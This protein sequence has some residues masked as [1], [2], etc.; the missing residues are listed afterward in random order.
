[1]A[2][3]SLVLNNLSF[4]CKLEQYAAVRAG[5][6]LEPHKQRCSGRPVNAQFQGDPQCSPGDSDKSCHRASAVSV[7]YSRWHV[8]LHQ[9]L[10][11][12]GMCRVF[13]HR[14]P[15]S[16]LARNP[17]ES[18][19]RF[20]VSWS[21]W[22]PQPRLRTWVGRTQTSKVSFFMCIFQTG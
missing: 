17:P 22:F 6:Q 21:W 4:L 10:P 18:I 13:G 1:M 12:G 19:Q 20:T 8:E 2:N 3:R 5:K 15:V 16:H 7:S 11:E 14:E 9:L